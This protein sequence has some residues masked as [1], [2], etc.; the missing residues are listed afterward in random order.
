MET[1]NEQ[2]PPEIAAAIVTVAKGIKPLEKTERNKFG[3]YNYVSVDAY[4]AAIRHLMAEAG[5]IILCDEVGL[6]SIDVQDTKVPDKI[7]TLLLS[8]TDGLPT[9]AG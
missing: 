2:M 8:R 6:D 7:N 5:L 3:G 1:N 9:Q 4:Y